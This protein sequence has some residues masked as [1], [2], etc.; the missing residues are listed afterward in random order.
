MVF[1]RKYDAYMAT[2][3]KKEIPKFLRIFFKHTWIYFALSLVLT[4]VGMIMIEIITPI[5]K[6]S[7][8]YTWEGIGMFLAICAGIGW[9]LHGT[10][11]LLVRA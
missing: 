9:V 7:I 3:I 5:Q 6:T 8:I 1:E 2:P 4:L 11:F 10:G